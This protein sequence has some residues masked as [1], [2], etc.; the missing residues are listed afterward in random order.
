WRWG[1]FGAV[2][3]RS[4]GSEE[5]RGVPVLASIPLLSAAERTVDGKVLDLPNYC[6]TKPLSQYAEAVRTLRMGVQMADVDD[7]AKVVLITSSVPKEGK[8]T[9]ALSLAYS[10]M[11]AGLRTIVIDG[12]LRHPSMSK[13]FDV[14]ASPG[15]V[16]LLTG[17][18]GAE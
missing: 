3:F 17:V 7:P 11:Q 1:E 15:L 5:S 10:A 16:D 2:P 18:K 14:H 6:H 13:Y 8:S 9:I 12:D 4:S